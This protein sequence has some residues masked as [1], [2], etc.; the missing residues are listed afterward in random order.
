MVNMMNQPL[1]LK[2]EFKLSD[3]ESLQTLNKKLSELQG[4]SGIQKAKYD[5]THQSITIEYDQFVTSYT[6]L[7]AL[8]SKLNIHYKKGF[9]FKLKTIW[10]DYLDSTSKAN[11][12]APPRACCNKPPKR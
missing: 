3:V 11:A 8:L 7:L 2:H 10:Y 9:G 5:D 4:K 6:G 12:L 1:L